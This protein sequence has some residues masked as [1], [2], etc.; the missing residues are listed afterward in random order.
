[1]IL[2]NN[3]KLNAFFFEVFFCVSDICV[4]YAIYF[5]SNCGLFVGYHSHTIHCNCVYHASLGKVFFFL[6]FFC[7]LSFFVFWGIMTLKLQP[8][9]VRSTFSKKN[10]LNRHMLL[11]VHVLVIFGHF[12]WYYV[13]IF[14][15]F[16]FFFIFFYQN[17]KD[18]IT[19]WLS[20]FLL[21]QKYIQ[22]SS[23]SYLLLILLPSLVV[24][25]DPTVSFSFSISIKDIVNQ[26]RSL[27]MKGR[28]GLDCHIDWSKESKQYSY[29]AVIRSH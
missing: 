11:F 4:S 15:L 6:F 14:F 3:I 25:T 29:S 7:V 28:G 23:S 2:F 8:P 1:M 12:F 10:G 24:L 13:K 9:S 27:K 16:R 26:H 20:S 21:W 18:D 17:L 5:R 22:Q 19:Y